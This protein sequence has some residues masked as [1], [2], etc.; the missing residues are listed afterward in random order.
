MKHWGQVG[1]AVEREMRSISAQ[2][3]SFEPCLVMPWSWL[4]TSDSRR[5]GVSPGPRAQVPW[6]RE[7]GDVTDLGDQDGGDRAADP[8]VACTA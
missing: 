5:P 8:V 1:P 2:R 6:S 4:L 3:N 7:A